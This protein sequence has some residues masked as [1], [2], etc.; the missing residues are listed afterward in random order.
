MIYLAKVTSLV[1]KSRFDQAKATSM[2]RKSRD[3]TRP[4]LPLWARSREIWWAYR[5]YTI[6]LVVDVTLLVTPEYIACW[7]GINVTFWLLLNSHKDNIYTVHNEWHTYTWRTLSTTKYTHT[8]RTLST[9]NDNICN[10]HHSHAIWKDIYFNFYYSV[11]IQA[12]HAYYTNVIWLRFQ[13]A[14][15]T[16]YQYRIHIIFISYI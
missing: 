10:L 5:F 15:F 11:N 8:W 13:Y 6:W 14:M 9:T 7:S 1:R 2:G 3:L 4:K 16:W 12:M